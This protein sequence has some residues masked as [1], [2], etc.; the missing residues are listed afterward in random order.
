MAYE[1]HG[2][3]GTPEYQAWRNM[4]TRTTNRRDPGYARYGERGIRVCAEWSKSFSAFYAHVGERPAPGYSLDR[5]DNGR[6]YE[7][8]NVRWATRRKQQQNLR[9]NLNITHGGKTL[10]LREWSR[11]SGVPKETIRSRI[12]RGWAVEKALTPTCDLPPGQHCYEV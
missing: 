5:I 7:P 6:G 10:C 1:Q 11:L 3:T 9:S 8:G 12:L 2:M 4:I